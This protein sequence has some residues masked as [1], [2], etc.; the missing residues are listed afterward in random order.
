MSHN[1]PN[2]FSFIVNE[3]SALMEDGRFQVLLA[4][5]YSKVDRPDD[6]V[7]SLQQVRKIPSFVKEWGWVAVSEGNI[8]LKQSPPPPPLSDQKAWGETADMS[9]WM[10]SGGGWQGREWRRN[11]TRQSN[12]SLHSPP[13][14]PDHTRRSN[15]SGPAHPGQ[16][17][18]QLSS[19]R[20]TTGDCTW[21]HHHHPESRVYIRADSCCRVLH[22]FTC[23]YD[24]THPSL[25]DRRASSQP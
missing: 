6:A 11:S 1:F 16:E 19:Q 23:M 3:L 2:I 20:V 25:E 12:H 24:D 21:T 14:S 13:A 15:S 10:G 9:W 8:P 18:K 5:V 7:T 17:D 22:G 4:K